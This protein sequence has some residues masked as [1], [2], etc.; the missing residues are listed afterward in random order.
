MIVLVMGKM[1]NRLVDLEIDEVS[2]VDRAANQHSLIAFSKSLALGGETSED[3][4]ST[5]YLEDGTEVS[6]EDLQPGDLVVDEDGNETMLLPEDFLPEDIDDEF[7]KADLGSPGRALRAASRGLRGTPGP[8]GGPGQQRMYDAGNKVRRKAQRANAQARGMYNNAVYETNRRVADVGGAM[9]RRPFMTAGIAAGGGAALGAGG[10]YAGQRMKKSLGAE[11]LEEFSKAV[12]D[13]DREVV[14]AKM[15]GEV[16][17]ANMIAEDAMSW[18]E[19]EHDA[20]MTEA[21]ISKAAEYNLPVDPYVLGPI[22]KNMAE[23]LDEDELEV[24]EALFN[25]VG[26]ALYD[27]IGYMGDASSSSVLDQVGA[28]ANELV[29]KSDASH[30]QAMTAMFEANPMAYDAYLSEMGR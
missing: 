26:D 27:E 11:I 21:F 30:A 1:V 28:Y 24:I 29:T 25:A 10:M 18:A 7:G 3:R 23:A 20:R 8:M 4:M 2:V 13:R 14:I 22:L 16:D 6:E 17:R 12:T 19:S 5:F 15:A 9:A